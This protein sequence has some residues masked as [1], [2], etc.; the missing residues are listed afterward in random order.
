MRRR[1]ALATISACQGR[2]TPDTDPVDTT[3]TVD[4]V[5]GTIRRLP[6]ADALDACIHVPPDLTLQPQDQA[7]TL[8]T[9]RY[10][11][12]IDEPCPDAATVL[13]W[14][15]SVPNAGCSALGR[16]VCVTGAQG[17]VEAPM[18]TGWL[19]DT[20]TREQRTDV[21]VCRYGC[22]V[23]TDGAE[24]GRPLRS[25][26]GA[27]CV[28]PTAA[29]GDWSAEAGSFEGLS[30]GVRQALAARWLRDAALEHASIASFAR[31]ALDLLAHGA[32]AD[33]VTR[34][35][36]AQQDE[37]VH[38]RAAF[39]I[40]SA[41]LGAPVGPGPLDLP[42][43]P[44]PSLATLAAD[45]VRDGCCNEAMAAAEAAARLARATHPALR[46]SLARVVDDEARHAVLAADVVAWAIEVG[47]ADVQAAVDAAWEVARRAPL[48]CV[49]EVVAPD[50]GL[51]GG[52]SLARAH[53]VVREVV[54]PV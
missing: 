6:G 10:N 23:V 7:V 43:G 39:S 29:R 36:Q 42:A 26:D 14:N 9:C 21:A 51:C 33:L 27:L 25:A 46:A 47:G 50:V 19:P 31:L 2:K 20:A 37:V 54:F 8:A 48:A 52:A 13:P 32:P 3:D 15:G 35:V 4:T 53:A 34:V 30:D 38:A 12:P 22:V 1:K 24:C 16:T 44:T 28:A 49:D 5:A 41:L 11:V 17:R 18:E 40:A 45:T